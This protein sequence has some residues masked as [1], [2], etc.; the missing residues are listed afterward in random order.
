MPVASPELL[1]SDILFEEAE[2]EERS[3]DIA[4]QAQEQGR[5]EACAMHSQ[6]SRR[7]SSRLAQPCQE[8]KEVED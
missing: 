1:V 5:G 2:R 6:V 3:K 4:R 7:T 8:S